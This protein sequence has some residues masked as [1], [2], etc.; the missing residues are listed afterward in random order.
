M[1]PRLYVLPMGFARTFWLGQRA[2][3]SLSFESASILST[4]IFAE[5]RPAPNIKDKVAF[6]PYVVNA[7]MISAGPKQV[8]IVRD[9]I[10]K[11]IRETGLGVHEITDPETKFDTLGVSVIGVRLVVSSISK[12]VRK[13]LA[14][15]GFLCSGLRLNDQQLEHV[16]GHI[17]WLLCFASCLFCR[18]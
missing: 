4:Q 14:V 1:F 16:L 12:R 7:N 3:V 10:T 11:M 2:H 17:F 13:V 5:G 8:I 18:F 9:K 15:L 6:I